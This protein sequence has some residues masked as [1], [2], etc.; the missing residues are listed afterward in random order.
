LSSAVL[1]NPLK[2]SIFYNVFNCFDF[3]VGVDSRH[4]RTAICGV[5]KPCVAPVARLANDRI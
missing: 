2:A 5:C 4:T 3:A 1:D